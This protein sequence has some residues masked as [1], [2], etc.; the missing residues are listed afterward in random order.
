MTGNLLAG[1]I[2]LAVGS[3]LNSIITSLS[4]EGSLWSGRP[5]CGRCQQTLPWGTVTFLLGYPWHRGRCCFCGEPLPWRHPAVEVAAALLAVALWRRF[6]GGGLLGV[7]ASFTAALLV[8]TVLDLQYF[9]LPDVLT[10][11]GT[12]LGLAGALIF[13]PLSFWSALL[14]A[15]LGFAFFRGVA[16]IYGLATRGKRQGVGAG[17]AKLMAFIGAVLGVQALPWVLFSS[18]ALGSLAGLMVARRSR[19]GRFTPIPYG[20]FLAVGAL[21]FLFWKA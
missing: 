3:L 11:P 21:G 15:F 16:W 10:L 4:Q 6:P 18:A 7:Y 20:P 17:D 9:W 14:G 2:G 13:P 19:L 1:L 8:L 5:V 12:I